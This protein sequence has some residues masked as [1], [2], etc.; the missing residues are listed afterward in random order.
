MDVQHFYESRVQIRTGED[1]RRALERVAA[2]LTDRAHRDMRGEGFDPQSAELRFV[3]EAADGSRQELQAGHP[4]PAAVEASSGALLRLM[5]TI[6]LAG[7]DGQVTISPPASHAAGDQRTIGW[8]HGREPTAVHSLPDIAS[9]NRIDGPALAETAE[10]TCVIPPQWHAE[11]DP[12]GALK[13]WR[14]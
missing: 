3:L 7:Q 13:V 2:G 14:E 4:D 11:K 9:G 8:T 10:T 1:Q 5:A 6:E 12:F